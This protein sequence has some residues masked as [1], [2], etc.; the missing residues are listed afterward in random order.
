MLSLNNKRIQRH[1]PCGAEYSSMP[2]KQM[3]QQSAAEAA[4][5]E[6]AWIMTFRCDQRKVAGALPK[7]RSFARAY[8]KSKENTYTYIYIYMYIKTYWLLHLWYF[9][10][11]LQHLLSGWYDFLTDICFW[12][13][14]CTSSLDENDKQDEI[15]VRFSEDET[16]LIFKWL[17]TKRPSHIRRVDDFQPNETLEVYS[18]FPFWKSRSLY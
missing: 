8:Q 18:T 7:F 10:E 16:Q 5:L 9:V 14:Y 1:R 15:Y 2:P 6:V 4:D 13:T 11:E 17:K 12:Q 3:R